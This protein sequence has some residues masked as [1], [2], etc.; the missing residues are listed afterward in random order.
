[1]V[2]TLF[3]KLQ[4]EAPWLQMETSMAKWRTG[5]QNSIVYRHELHYRDGEKNGSLP[6]E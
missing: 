6:L 2:L 1:M 4:K 5:Y 3:S